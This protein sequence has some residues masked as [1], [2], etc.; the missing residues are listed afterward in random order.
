MQIFVSYLGLM[1]LVGL[2]YLVKLLFKQG[3]SE[4]SDNLIFKDVGSTNDNSNQ[5]DEKVSPRV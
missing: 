1:A 5:A 2:Y 4:E 3:K